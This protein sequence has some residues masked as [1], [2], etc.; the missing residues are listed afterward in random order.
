VIGLNEQM[1]L[2]GVPTVGFGETREE[3]EKKFYGAMIGLPFAGLV[4]GAAA[5]AVF[6]RAKAS[7]AALGAVV[8]GLV[9]G[10]GG[11]VAARQVLKSAAPPST[12]TASPSAA[13]GMGNPATANCI[14]KGGRSVIIET[15]LGQ[16]GV[17][18]FPDGSRCEE[19]RFFHGTCAPGKCR[20]ENGVC[21]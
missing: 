10:A 6:G 11:I 16:S 13:P 19:W 12:T 7:T 15:P 4:A 2:N 3:G 17:C 5:G 20:A 14:A 18:V 9:G 1:Y 21:P 8:G